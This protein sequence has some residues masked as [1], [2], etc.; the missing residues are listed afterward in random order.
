M[1]F[2]GPG[3]RTLSLDERATLANMATECSARTA[4]VEADDEDARAGSPTMRPGVDVER[5]ARARSCRPIP[6]PSTPAASTR[7]TSSTIRP[8]V[9]HPG[10]PDRGIPSDPTNGACIDEIGEVKIDIAYGGSCT[11]G[12]SDDLDLL[13]PGGEGGGRRRP[14]GRRRACSSIIQFGSQ[15]VETFAREQR[16]RSTPSSAPASQRDQPRLRRLHRL[17]PGRLRDAATRSRSSAINRNYKGRSGPGKLWLASP[18]TVAA[19]A[20]TGRIT[21]YTPGM[22]ARLASERPVLSPA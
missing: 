13:P 8:M 4:I 19:S 12:K 15:A 16:P 21:A 1:E 18:L 14:A 7:S 10:D 17:R 9:A 5:A 2:T 20:F 3:L 22:F 6:A 11:A